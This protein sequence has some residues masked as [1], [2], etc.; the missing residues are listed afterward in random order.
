[1]TSEFYDSLETRNPE[2]RER[3]L[4]VALPKHLKQA[5]ARS[6]FLQQQLQD[7]EIDSI[8]SREALAQLPVVRK[9]ELAELQKNSPPFGGM[10][11]FDPDS[12]VR[13]FASPG[14]IF[15][16]ETTREDSW[17]MSRALFAAGFR[18]GM[19]V[20]NTFSYHFSPAGAMLESGISVLGGA[21]FPAGVGQTELQVQAIE[22]LRPQGYTG[23]PSFLKIILEAAASSGA[24]VSS[25]RIGLV[26]GEALP[27]SLRSEL[28]GH[29]V[30][31]KQAYATADVGLIAYESDAME[32]L[33]LDEGVIVEIVRPGTGDPVPEG[34]VGEVVVTVINPDYPLV[35]FGTGDMSAIMSGQSP[36]GRTNTRIKGW[37]GRADQTT[38]VRGMF[39]HPS[40]V[41][42]IVK[43]CSE[44]EKARLVVSSEDHQD[45]MVLHCEVTERPDGLTD[46]IV[47]CAREVCK[48]RADVVLEEPGALANDGIVIED[49]RTYD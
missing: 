25:L 41:A 8:D 12:L 2:V 7:V 26:S 28:D 13:I 3:E 48:L 1:M 35:R 37:M 39:V 21:V 4:F 29:G 17:R 10:T 23:T 40:Q 30:S 32:G 22:R 6:S 16:P 11:A 19:L 5:S 45:N 27:P 18:K 36:C 20:H 34:N 43:R 46:K 33:I 14:P 44:V 9:S 49:A 42:Q 31:V 15:E 38:K 24:D 47:S